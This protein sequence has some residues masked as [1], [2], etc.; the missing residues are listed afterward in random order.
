MEIKKNCRTCINLEACS[1]L[2]TDILV[3]RFH[4]LI[5]IEV[6]DRFCDRYEMAD[7]E[8]D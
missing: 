8:V 4:Y 2:T 3:C 1:V 5:D 7:M 6:D